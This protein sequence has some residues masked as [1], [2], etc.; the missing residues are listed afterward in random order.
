[1]LSL[2][3]WHKVITISG[4]YCN[5]LVS[6]TIIFLDKLLDHSGGC[7]F[8]ETSYKQTDYYKLKTKY[9]FTATSN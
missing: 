5:N 7:K 4:F 2:M 3:V 6:M 1:M 9:D 8:L